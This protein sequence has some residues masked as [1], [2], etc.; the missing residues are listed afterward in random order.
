M[1]VYIGYNRRTDLR[2]AWLSAAN[3]WSPSTQTLRSDFPPG[4]PTYIMYEKSFPAG[5]IVLGGPHPGPADVASPAHY[6]TIVK[7]APV[8]ATSTAMA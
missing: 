4:N 3:G 2:P 5:Q 8:A 1:I 7:P 6:V